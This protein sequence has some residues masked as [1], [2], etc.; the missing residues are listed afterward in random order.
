MR[1]IPAVLVLPAALA[2]AAGPAAAQDL[3]ALERSNELRAEQMMANQRAVALENQFNALDARI[4]TE[5]ALRA[6]HD[7]AAQPRLRIPSEPS[8]A[9]TPSVNAAAPF[10][11]IPDDRLAAS[12]A[13]V[14]EASGNRR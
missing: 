3:Y 5:Q 6:L 1:R 13:R 9:R 14:R 7:Q 10:A 12:N 8:T 4:R 11:A 2:L